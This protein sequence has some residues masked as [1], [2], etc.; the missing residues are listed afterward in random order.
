MEFESVRDESMVKP[1]KGNKKCK[2]N[3]EETVF[4][5]QIPNNISLVHRS[6]MPML[7]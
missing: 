4:L 7:C 6:V 1:L 2:R 5:W 3:L